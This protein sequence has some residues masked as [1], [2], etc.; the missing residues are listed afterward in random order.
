MADEPDKPNAMNGLVIQRLV[1]E[2][3]ITHE[4]AR[5]LVAL[6][7]LNWSSLMREAK[8]LRRKSY[9]GLSNI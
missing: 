4:E 3:G 9:P 8:L 7:G 6:L 5:E 1:L 2:T